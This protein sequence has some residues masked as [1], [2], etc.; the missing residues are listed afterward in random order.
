[1]SDPEGSTCIGR[2][3]RQRSAVQSRADFLDDIMTCNHMHGEAVTFWILLK[4]FGSF[5]SSLHEQLHTK[6]CHIPRK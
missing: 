1:M 6:R 4:V 2:G 3:A 5:W